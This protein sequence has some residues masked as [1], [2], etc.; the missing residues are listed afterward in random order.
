[1]S[2][3]DSRELQAPRPAITRSELAR[4]RRGELDASAVAA[5]VD[6]TV[7][8]GAPRAPPEGDLVPNES[9]WLIGVGEPQEQMYPDS[10]WVER[11]SVLAFLPGLVAA[12]LTHF[13]HVVLPAG[14]VASALIVTSI[15]P[16][17]RLQRQLKRA[18]QVAHLADVPEGTLV[19]VSGTIPPQAT[20]PTLFRGIPAVLFRTR[21]DSAQET[22]GLDFLLDLD[23]GEQAK[24][25]VRSGFLLEPPKRTREP[26]ACGP[27]SPHA[28]GRVYVLR[29][30]ML[31][32]PPLLSRLFGRYESSVGPGDRIEV[33]GIVRHV[34][35]PDLRSL[36]Q[37]PTRPVLGA[38]E[39]TPLLVRRPVVA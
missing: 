1:M 2:S 29:S 28:V 7:G 10:K 14:I 38:G 39:D 24:V 34:F 20:V 18:R 32:R 36:R 27:V 3:S 8:L 30:D 19:R 13:A 22:R 15:V 31:R 37:V 16:R 9:G 25:A 21:M 23:N 12:E 5:L 33:C 26:P 11:L 35:S 4:L 6:R 17:V